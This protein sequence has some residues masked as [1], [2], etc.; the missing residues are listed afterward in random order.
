MKHKLLL[1]LMLFSFGHL[2][3]EGFLFFY[4]SD[5]DP[6]TDEKDIGLGIFEDDEGDG[7]L[8]GIYCNYDS[9]PYIIIVP[10]RDVY[11]SE[12]YLNVT[13]RFD[14][15]EPFEHSFLFFEGSVVSL[16][17]DF[18]KSFIGDLA[19]ANKLVAK[20]QDHDG[21]FEF[22]DLNL[23]KSEMTKFK[24]ATYSFPQCDLY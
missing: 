11:S 19:M 6:F 3:A 24:S 9:T 15:K 14:K 12:V 5:E 10:D 21:Y 7:T 8:I 1:F 18:I 4:E 13:F 20:I 22:T 16:D 23:T 17:L 2:N